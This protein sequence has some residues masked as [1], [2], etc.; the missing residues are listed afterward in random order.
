MELVQKLLWAT[1]DLSKKNSTWFCKMNILIA[2]WGDPENW[3][4]VTYKFDD[5]ECRSKSS[6]TPLV[7]VIKPDLTVI[8]ALDTLAKT[9]NSYEEL[10]NETKNKIEEN[11]KFVLNSPNLKP[12]EEIIVA[13][14]VG[15]FQNTVFK[16]RMSDFYAYL[17]FKLSQLIPCNDVTFHID[18]THGIN[19]TPSLT[20]R[21]IREIAGIMAVTKEI[22]IIVYNSEPYTADS[23]ELKIHVVEDSEVKPE[24]CL[25]IMGS[26]KLLDANNLSP[27]QRKVIFR[28]ELKESREKLDYM[29]NN[30]FL[31]SVVNG[32]PLT[33]CTFLPNIGDLENCLK[34]SVDVFRRYIHV[35]EEEKVT[36]ERLLTF[37]NDFTTCTK[38][39]LT[40]RIIGVSRK[41]E[42]TLEELDDIREKIF[43]KVKKLNSIISVD[44]KGPN[45]LERTIENAIAENKDFDRWILLSEIMGG[46]LQE[47][48]FRNFLAH[49][50]L[51]RNITE[52]KF[53]K[54]VLGGG[55]KK[56]ILR[57]SEKDKAKKLALK[58]VE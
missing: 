51:E 11:L 25:E 21:A 39:Y 53:D 33:L 4:E 35:S 16:G 56:A 43:S 52:V 41:A 8:I 40:A 12:S 5:F 58:G 28:D 3:N 29:E 50:G 30:A 9:G 14:S 7:N 42:V 27:E 22:Q 36:V 44:L 19:Y 1:G 15:E 10:I 54:D 17:L 32:L 2:P 26:D 47:A 6:L 31:S 23:G 37:N 13:P 24:P 38:A 55:I 34:N 48:E 45:G 46:N 57:Y 18:L 20:Y 49:S